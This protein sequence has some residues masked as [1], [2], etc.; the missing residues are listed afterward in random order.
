MDKR[1]FLTYVGLIVLVAFGLREYF[2]TIAEVSN[3]FVGDSSAYMAYVR[4]LLGEGVFGMDGTPDAFRGP[5]YPLF[6]AAFVRYVGHQGQGWLHPLIQ[7]QVV[8]GTATVALTI[9]LAR[10][11]L[12]RPWS[13]VAGALMAF[14]AHHIVATD[15]LLTEVLF[16]FLVVSAL[17]ATVIAL[18]RRS[19][20]LAALAGLAFGLG[21]LVN[22]VIALF[23]FLLVPV[24]WRDGLAREGGILL[25]V[26]L[27]AVGGWSVRNHVSHAQNDTRAAMNFVQG[28]WPLYHA[29]ANNRAKIHEAQVVFDAISAEIGLMQTDPFGAG[30]RSVS[31]RFRREPAVY[32]RWYASKP[33]LLWD[34]E[35]RIGAGGIYTQTVD[36]SPLD[37]NPALRLAVTLQRVLN[38]VLF[39]LALAFAAI[40][41]WRKTPGAFVVALCCVY[42]TAVYVVFQ[43]EPRYAIPFRSLEM[44]LCVGALSYLSG[45]VPRRVEVGDFG[46]REGALVELSVVALAVVY[47]AAAV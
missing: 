21:Y 7:A 5:G 1:K 3:P 24:F 13:L 35:I 28:S 20:A 19:L 33:Y 27:L 10:E 38:P 2:V 34:W 29:A 9:A 25:L 14:Q 22:P 47:V 17:L 23:P 4:H 45:I 37:R 15:F 18:R 43:A 44:L 6:I 11:W 32:A 31:E 36:K 30:L 26:S 12:S 8:L 46:G 41:L 39:A 40:A 16:G 42:V